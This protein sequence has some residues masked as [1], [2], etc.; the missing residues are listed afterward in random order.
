MAEEDAEE[1]DADYIMVSR[2]EAGL[3]TAQQA[4]VIMGHLWA[5][6]DAGLRRRLLLLLH[7][8]ARA[9][10][11]FHEDLHCLQPVGCSFCC[12]AGKESL[13]AV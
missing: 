9:T 2:M 12:S 6:G 7:Q 5:T 3:Y 11:L 4:C 13:P 8:Q 1:V 10:V